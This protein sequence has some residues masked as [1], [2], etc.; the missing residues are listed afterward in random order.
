MNSARKTICW[1]PVHYSFT[2]LSII[3]TIFPVCF[4]L[5]S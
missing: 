1:V 5:I 2:M 4:A 3:L